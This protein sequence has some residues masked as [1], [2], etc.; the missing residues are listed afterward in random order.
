MPERRVIAGLDI[1]TSKVCAIIGET[2]C[3][4]ELNIFGVGTSPSYGLK[5]GMVVNLDKTVQAIAA[6][7]DA[8]ER[9]AG[10]EVSSVCVG[11][12]G[13]HITS[14]NSHGVVAVANS[15]EITEQDVHRVLEAAKVI[16]LPSDRRIIHVLPRE[17]IVDSCRGIKD[18]EGM[19]GKRLEVN[20]HIVTGAVTALQNIIKCV[21]RAG[22]EVED[23]VL[24]PIASSISVLTLDEQDSGTVLI[25][26]GGGTTDLAVFYEGSICH[27]GI[28]PVGGNHFTQDLAFGLRIPFAEAERL[29]L[30]YSQ[31]PFEEIV[32]PRSEEL[33]ILVKEELVKLQELNIVPVQCVLTGGSSQLH[34]LKEI[35]Q[36]ILDLP[37]RIG[38]PSEVEGLFDMI[39][40]PV[41]ATGI[42]LLLYSGKYCPPDVAEASF[43]S[44]W[45]N[46]A[47]RIKQWFK[48]FIP[49]E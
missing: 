7:V 32:R 41:Y 17:F 43:D 22:L 45:L 44:L 49:L 46:L 5:K 48:D 15:N 8:A 4:G 24:Q 33:F 11:V 16:A 21:E 9:M 36:T 29:K 38:S 47:D 39:N 31:E 10:I 3:Y 35:A 34:G 12:A 14:F 37:V 40:S 25:D 20:V 42:G 18:P 6:A 13:G 19:A 2:G 1:G 26:I 27:T 23:L 28:I 30:Q